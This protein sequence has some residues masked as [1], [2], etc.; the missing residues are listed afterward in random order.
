MKKTTIA[1][2]AMG[3]LA[4]GA[5]PA[6]SS[7]K[8]YGVLDTAIEHLSS[9]SGQSATLMMNTGHVPSR[10]G[11]SGSEDLGGGLEAGFALE[12]PIFVDSGSLGGTKLFGRQSYVSLGAR[13]YGT[14]RLGRQY[15]V[16]QTALA[17]YDPDHFSPYS[18]V[19]AMQL[20]NFDQTSLDN[21]ISYLSPQWGGFTLT[22]TGA[23]GEKAALAA[24][25]VNPQ[26][27]G[28]GTARNTVSGMLQYAD[29]GLGAVVA[30]QAGGEDLT[31]GG[32]ARQR[33]YNAGVN[34]KFDDYEIG[35]VYWNHRNTLSSGQAPAVDS[36]AL[37]GAWYVLPL[38]RLN[39]ELGRAADN[40][41]TYTGS[42]KA[43]GR[44]N[45]YNLGATYHLSKRTA[46]YVRVGRITDENSGFNGRPVA[47][48]PAGREGV[49]VPV[50]GSVKGSLLGLRHTF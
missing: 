47:V 44:N 19:L 23:L 50:N 9:S 40:G 18:P 12:T 30:Y 13:G 4:C 36:I 39:L 15:S 45:Y 11:F 16:M 8:I 41:L 32:S 7:I 29:G 2:A 26:I 28:T 17:Q 14:L 35:A 46:V 31:A 37:G 21:A 27:V 49:A 48:S 6:Q 10:I 1:C 24:N 42:Q 3:L 34:Y 43:I 25:V 38:L 5:C 20:A 33:M 22:L